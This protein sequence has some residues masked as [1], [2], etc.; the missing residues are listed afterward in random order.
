MFET[1]C[2]LDY[3]KRENVEMMFETVRDYGKA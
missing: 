2:G 1:S 3:A